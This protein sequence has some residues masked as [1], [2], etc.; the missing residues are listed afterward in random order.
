MPGFYPCKTCRANLPIEDKHDRC[1][2]CLGPEHAKEA[3]AYR[4]VCGF[5]APFSK[6][7]LE[8][9]LSRSFKEHPASLT[10]AQSS[11]PSPSHTEMAASSPHGSVPRESGRFTD[12]VPARYR[13]G[14]KS[15]V[16]YQTWPARVLTRLIDIYKQIEAAPVHCIMPGF[17]PCETCRANLPIED[18]HDRCSSCLGPEHAKEAL[19]YRSV[20]GFCAPFS[21][22]TLEKWLSRSFKEHPASLT[23][24]QSSSPSPSHTEMAASSPHG[25]VPRES[26]RCTRESSP[27]R[28]LPSRSSSSSSKKSRCS[29]RSADAEQNS[30]Q[31]FTTEEPFSLNYCGNI[32]C[33]LPCPG[34]CKRSLATVGH[35]VHRHL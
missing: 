12:P 3:L 6:R 4:S 13:P 10:P 1:S 27:R 25:S 5:C 16:W 18:K 32:R 19:G 17:Y 15:P 20:C 23:P 29:R 28:R 33:P 14:L 7:T 2:S 11:S 30:G 26:G 34:G 9:R 22:R 21:K 31:L 8:K 35:I 24:A